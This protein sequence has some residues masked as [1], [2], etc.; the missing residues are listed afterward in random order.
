[1]FKVEVN[2]IIQGRGCSQRGS[3]FKTPHTVLENKFNPTKESTPYHD[4]VKGRQGSKYT[5][6]NYM[7]KDPRM[8]HCGKS[9]KK[10]QPKNMTVKYSNM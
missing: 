5:N 4:V 1:M 3:G 10:P 6:A 9:Y 8:R 7:I 2:N